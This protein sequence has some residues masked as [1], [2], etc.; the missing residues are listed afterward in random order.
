MTTFASEPSIDNGLLSPVH[1]QHQL[2]SIYSQKKTI[3]IR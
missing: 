3:R 1:R 2:C